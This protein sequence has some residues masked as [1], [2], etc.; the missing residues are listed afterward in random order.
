MNASDWIAA[1]IW[2]AVVLTVAAAICLLAEILDRI[3][4]KQQEQADERL[5]RRLRRRQAW[6]LVQALDNEE[7]TT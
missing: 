7:T 2:G 4:R 1:G 3:D 6:E 5:R